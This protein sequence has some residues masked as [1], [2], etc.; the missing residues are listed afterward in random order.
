MQ[1]NSGKIK[2]KPTTTYCKIEITIIKTEIYNIPI[3]TERN[4]FLNM[5]FPK[6][7]QN[8]NLTKT[9]AVISCGVRTMV[10]RIITDFSEI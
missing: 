7:L 8:R 9:T 1:V 5:K 10:F 6:L 4:I 3:N 2:K